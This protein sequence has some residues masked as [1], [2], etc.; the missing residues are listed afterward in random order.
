M[1]TTLTAARI[2]K[3]IPGP[4]DS[5]TLVEKI[6]VIAATI[7]RNAFAMPTYNVY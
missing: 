7:D 2:V 1:F 6:V 4:I 5:T 3:R